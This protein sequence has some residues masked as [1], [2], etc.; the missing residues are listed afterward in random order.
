MPTG[1]GTRLQSGMRVLDRSGA[2]EALKYLVT[3]EAPPRGET[4]SLAGALQQSDRD[5]F[6]NNVTE[7]R[8]VLFVERFG[9][10]AARQPQS[11]KVCLFHGGRAIDARDH[12][13]LPG[14]ELFQCV[15]GREADRL[16]IAPCGRQHG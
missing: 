1:R 2:D 12:W 15:T 9:I 3:Q 8:A 6:G 10:D 16:S 7:I 11:E 4:H 14:D 5:E 13:R